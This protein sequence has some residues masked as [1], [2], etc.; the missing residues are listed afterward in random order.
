MAQVPFDSERRGQFHVHFLAGNKSD[1][2]VFSVPRG[3][4][5]ADVS[6]IQ[7]VAAGSMR[8]A[9]S[10]EGSAEFPEV[11]TI[12]GWSDALPDLSPGVHAWEFLEDGTRVV[13]LC[14]EI[15]T[16]RFQHA[17]L[18]LKPGDSYTIIKGGSVGLLGAISLDDGSERDGLI[19]FAAIS[20]D[21]SFTAKSRVLGVAAWR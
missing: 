7:V 1:R 15:G 19:R 12:G 18:D 21:V 2:Y 9:T 3:I 13:G 5:R 8:M 20:R 6:H 10:P 4:K 17:K 16:G 14:G 11:V